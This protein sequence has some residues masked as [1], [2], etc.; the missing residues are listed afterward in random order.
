MKSNRAVCEYFG[1][2]QGSLEDLRV[3]EEILSRPCALSVVF[4]TTKL[5]SAPVPPPTAVHTSDVSKNEFNKFATETH[6]YFNDL[7]RSEKAWTHSFRALVL[8][9]ERHTYR[10]IV[11]KFLKRFV[12]TPH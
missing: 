10:V 7:R 4:A 5:T 9:Q 11:T 3:L 12:F 2:S 8:M 6:F 1:P